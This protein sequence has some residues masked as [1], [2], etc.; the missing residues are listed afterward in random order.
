MLRWNI[1]II[2]TSQHTAF[3]SCIGCIIWYLI[4]NNIFGDVQWRVLPHSLSPP[5]IEPRAFCVW[6]KCGNHYHAGVCFDHNVDRVQ[7]NVDRVLYRTCCCKLKN[8][9]EKY[10]TW[11]F[12][13]Y[14]TET[15]I[16]IVNAVMY[17]VNTRFY[18]K[19]K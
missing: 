13:L 14:H 8:G 9:M 16:Y 10:I 18:F 3:K 6:S 4:Y 1:T 11:Q 15:S 5:G 2:R 17:C 19:P 7:S 12:Y